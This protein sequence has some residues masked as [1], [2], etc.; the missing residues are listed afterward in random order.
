M[1]PFFIT[2]CF[3]L[4]LLS[5]S[6]EAATYYISMS[7]D[8]NNPGI[9]KDLPWASITKVNTTE[10]S[11]G[12]SILFEA[13]SSFSG[14]LDFKSNVKGTAANPI[15]I[16]SYGTGKATINS[17]SKEGLYVYNSAGFKIHNIKFAGSGRTSNTSNG[18]EFYMDLP[19]NARLEYIAI[20]NVEISGYHDTGLLIGSWKGTS[21]YDSISVTNSMIHDNGIGGIATY[22]EALHGHTKLY[23]GNNKIFN[24]T[25]LKGQKAHTGN[26]IMIGGV[27]GVLI[28]YCEVYNNG[29]LSDARDTGPA[30][31]WA[32]RCNNVLIQYNEAYHNKTGGTK[33]GGG[34]D[35]DG[36]V[37]NAVMQYNYSHD[38]DG[39]GFLVSQHNGAAPLK[40]VV[41]RYNIS[42]NDGRKNSYA[43]IL[44]WSSGSGGGIQNVEVYNNTV[45]LTPSKGGPSA[46]RLFGKL[47]RN[48]HIWNNIFQTT[49]GTV[50]T[51]TNTADDA[52]I[53]F[54]GNSYWNAGE[55]LKIDWKKKSFTSLE[56]WQK[57]TGQE[58]LDGT[59]AGFFS[60]PQLKDPGKGVTISDPA[61]FH[62]LSGYELQE[63]SP[64]ID[65]GLDLAALF[66]TNIGLTDFFG[67]ELKD[68]GKF[69][70]GAFQS[71]KV[72][73]LPVTLSLFSVSRQGNDAV[74]YWETASEQN[75]KGF[76]VEVSVDGERFRTLAFVSSKSSN[77]QQAQQYTYRDTE[78]GK[79]GTYYYRLQQVDF[80]GTTTYSAVQSVT[81]EQEQIASTVYPNPFSDSFILELKAD[82]AEVL[83]LHISDAVG[84]QVLRR[85]VEL[86]KGRNKVRFDFGS[87]QPAGLYIISVRHGQESLQLKVLKQ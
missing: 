4:A 42:E 23:V 75:N 10:F 73:P 41:I 86:L 58:K 77:T 12:D 43:G 44:F 7:G 76:A 30:G 63:T 39:A 60:D 74:L 25:G 56:E 13:N 37:T 71:K 83:Q 45:Y 68:E 49:P 57:A 85:E 5:H 32:Y 26:G 11:P 9:K 66:G 52:E 15:Y 34:F 17:G 78:S 16:G 53:V 82:E 22:A 6:L 20:D 62:T 14:S 2:T 64:L 67:N 70:V 28:E 59:P 65:N 40:N 87:Q 84:R 24:N 21:G 50:L 31:I 79:A 51:V 80:D 36:G 81:F 8:D 27:D 18:V 54:Q 72:V 38:N 55:D 1:K 35:I 29:E 69:T 33:D 19:N 61:K 47:Y 46:I 3:V 48:V